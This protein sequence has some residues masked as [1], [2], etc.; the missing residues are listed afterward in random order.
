M[1]DADVV[2]GTATLFQHAIEALD[3]AAAVALMREDVQLY[4]P[5]PR[6]PFEGRDV[7]AGCL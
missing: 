1:V 3:T 6:A 7:V 5:V 2:R 4:S